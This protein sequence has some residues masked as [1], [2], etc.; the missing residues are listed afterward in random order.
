VRPGR[1]PPIVW[2]ARVQSPSTHSSSASWATLAADSNPDQA[3]GLRC[4]PISTRTG[5]ELMRGRPVCGS[6]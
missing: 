6:M 2:R 4:G 1:P 5:I 3:F